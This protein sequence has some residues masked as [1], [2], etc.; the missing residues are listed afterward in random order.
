MILFLSIL[1]AL[2]VWA[3]VAGLSAL[4]SDGYGDVELTRRNRLPESFPRDR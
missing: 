3:V 4:R 2:L 1:M